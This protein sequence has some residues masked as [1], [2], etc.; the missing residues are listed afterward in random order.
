MLKRAKFFFLVW[1]LLFA[2]VQD[3]YATVTTI[4][5][6]GSGTFTVPAGVTSVTIEGWGGGGPGGAAG[7][8]VGGGGGGEG[9]YGTKVLT[10]SPGDTISYVVGAVSTTAQN[11]GNASTLTYSAVTYTSNGGSKGGTGSGITGGTGGPGGTASGYTTNTTGANGT[12]GSGSA[13]GHSTGTNP[14]HG[15]ASVGGTNTVTPTAGGQ[16]GVGGGGAWFITHTTPGVGAAGQVQFTYTA[17]A[18][19]PIDAIWFGSSF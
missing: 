13:G 1:L 2:G 8:S 12:A 11:P 7:G 19:A 6:P 3:A 9:G 17:S 10:V 16:P 4:T 15:T 18:V 14:S 5:T